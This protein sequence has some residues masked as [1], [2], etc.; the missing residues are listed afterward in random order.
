MHIKRENLGMRCV[1]HPEREARV[2]CNY[3]GQPVCSD[4]QLQVKAEHYCRECV[5]AKASGKSRIEHS[6]VLA[7]ILSS[8]VG[9]LGQIYNGQYAKGLLIFFTSWL[10]IPWVI[11]IAD[12]YRTAVKIKNG[13]IPRQV[14][15]GCIVG[16][17]VAVCAGFFLA[18]V[19]VLVAVVAG[20]VFRADQPTPREEQARAVVSMIRVAAENY[21]VNHGGQ[22]PVSETELVDEHYLAEGLNGVT[23]EGYSYAVSLSAG[24]Y[25]IVA[26]PVIC[27]PITEKMF[28]VTHAGDIA[29]SSCRREAQEE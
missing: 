20:K 27:S 24:G 23:R 25:R 29:Q 19:L 14:K 2:R 11:G 7:V 4:C 17:L 28:T 12:A 5:S 21:A 8:V 16:S 18:G 1:N 22:F 9:G 13:L 3:C 26:E 6:P 10:V 15:A